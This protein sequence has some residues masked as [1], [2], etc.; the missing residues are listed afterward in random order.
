MT[1]ENESHRHHHQLLPPLQPQRRI[2]SSTCDLH[3]GETVTGF[4]ASCLRERLAGL[5]GPAAASGR[6]STSALRS[7]FSMVTVG[8][9][10]AAGP[11]SLRRSK[12]FSFSRGGDVF[13]AQR[14]RA[15][16][17]EPQ[18]RSCD[19]RGRSTLWSLFH[20]DDRDRVGQNPSIPP[21]SSSSSSS[22][23]ST[24]SAAA[25]ATAP[26]TSGAIEVDCRN[27]GLP[28]PSLAPPVSGTCEEYEIGHEIRPI[29]TSGEINEEGKG[30]AEEEMELKPM[31]DHINLDSEQQQQHQ[32]KK[33]P[34]KDFKEIASSVWLAASVFSKK[35]QKWRRRQKPKNQGGEATMPAEEPPKTSRRFH[36]TQSE[37]AMDCSGRRSCDT[38]PRFSLDA[39]RMSIDDPRFSWDEPR[40]SWDGY[41][42]GGRS[43][44]PRLPPILSVVEDAPAPAV[45][46]SDYLIPVEADAA[47][48][49]GSAQ[50]RD[51]YLDS[52]SQRRRSLDRS[53]S[54]REQPVEISEP[55][56]VSN[57]RV[58]PAG[59]MDF[60]PFH[61]GASLEREVKDWSSNSLRDDYSGSF[62]SAFRDLNKGASAKKS[63][64]WSKAWNIWGLLQR[65]NSSRGEANMVDR[66]LSE[67]WPE[68]RCK[69]TNG[70]ILRSNSSV[71]S[72]VSSHA[73]AGYG[74]MRTSSMRSSGNDKK[75]SRD[76]PVLERN[77]S[78]RYSPNHI[79]NGMLRFYLTPKR[80][81][82]RNGVSA[83]RRQMMPS[84]Y[85][86]RSMLGLY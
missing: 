81:A 57:S 44:F 9:G 52:S 3:P 18:R 72:R 22:S 54:I 60:F 70:R 65:R 10:P 41:L 59:G 29:G 77:R 33:P 55:K 75:K 12:S 13:S 76:E 8:A 78:A 24:S 39:A 74:V 11:S 4:C 56:P 58:S 46:R 36:D 83:S 47:I 80:N 84:P 1:V 86:A 66:S 17:L 53:S 62:E 68:L 7:V 42:I 34:Q 79:E 27:Q 37:V 2:P 45:Q 15:S 43:V 16:A 21:F 48:P 35:L 85:L 50:T 23:T 49:G 51:Y 6:R 31:K 82:R 71:S 63:S 30:A 19:V 69:S 14:P 73:N 26:S 40:A 25:A 67:S 32:A 20:Q 38:D 28:G 61:H 5:E 64:R